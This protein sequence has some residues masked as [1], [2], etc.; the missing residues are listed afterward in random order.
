MQLTYLI[1]A[2]FGFIFPYSQLIAFIIDHGLDLQLF[3]SQLFINHI[4][5]DFALDLFVSSVA[6]WFFLFQE[7]A[8]LKMRFL[9]IYVVLNLAIGMSFALPLFLFVRSQNI[10]E[11]QSS[12][13]A[14]QIV[15][16]A[17]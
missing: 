16:G 5:S 1:C 3:W 9:W 7:G 13:V 17:K 8:K 4:S 14:T 12:Y 2:I 10:D 15:R 11:A 6:F